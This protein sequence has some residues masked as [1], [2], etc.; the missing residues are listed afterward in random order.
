MNRRKCS[1]V[2]LLLSLSGLITLLVSACG[3]T[4]PVSIS[5]T[6]TPFTATAS[7][8]PPTN[9]PL[10]TTVGYATPSA[11]G[12]AF[13]SAV[14][15]AK[16]ATSYRLEMEISGKGDLG[17]TGS[18]TPSS[19]ATPSASP[20]QD[21]TLMSMKGEVNG[22]SAH[23]VLK[24]L[25]AAFLGVDPAKSLE[26]IS[27]GDKSYVHGPVPLIGATEDKWYVVPAN[28]ASVA[29]PPLTPDTFLS[30]FTTSGLNPNDFQK[31]GTESLDNLSCDVYSGDRAAIDKA[32]KSLGQSTGGADLSSID[33]AEFKFWICD[34]GFLHQIRMNVAGH[35]PDKPDQKGSFLL[36][37]HVSDIGSN[38]DI[39]AP[40]NAE[41]L[42]VPSGETQTPIP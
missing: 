39:T 38:I 23:F 8:L 17:L 16:S 29:K 40:Q 1:Q 35:S 5:G 18:E 13:G 42:I 21:I 14:E 11:A 2:G 30:S 22:Q 41:E 12:N 37:M 10:P 4:T 28:Q 26:L 34:D 19:D 6:Q 32:F 9:T 7:P 25:F 36:L 15:K 20:N 27:V 24:G 3:G 33:T 31:T